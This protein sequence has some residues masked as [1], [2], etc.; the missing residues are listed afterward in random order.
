MQY[1]EYA[2][3]QMA[4]SSYA[5]RYSQLLEF[6]NFLSSIDFSGTDIDE[7]IVTAWIHSL[8]NLSSSTVMT[9][10]VSIRKLF[11]YLSHMQL[12][13]CYM[14]HIK[15]VTKTYVA[16]YF[17]EEELLSIYAYA[18]DYPSGKKNP[19][20]YIKAE[21]PMI[22]RIIESCGTRLTETLSLQMKHVN[23]KQGVLTMV[24][25]K[26]DR[27]RFVPMSN[28]LTEMLEKYC[29]AMGLIG[30]PDYYIFPKMDFNSHLEKHDIDNRFAN[31]L[32]WNEIMAINR[33]KYGRGICPHCFRHN[34]ALKAFKILE[35]QGISLN[36]AIPYLSIY[37]GHDSL[38]ETEKYLCFSAEMF[39]DELKSFEETSDNLFPDDDIWNNIYEEIVE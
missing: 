29:L 6:D 31:I 23:L 17:T 4:Q 3:P 7:K 18:D 33:K 38:Q 28:S 5:H 9:Y 34:F 24:H 19:L 35:N 36:D 1:M 13:K 2:K 11:E 25:T 14:P 16:H 21:L 37:L 39:P 8:S 20:P 26:K 15:R 10:V 12:M 30:M 22:L 27:E 32:R